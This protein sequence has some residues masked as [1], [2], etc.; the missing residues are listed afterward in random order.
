M[1]RVV[2]D[3]GRSALSI[4][5]VNLDNLS[6]LRR[7]IASI[8]GQTD[9]DFE[10][11]V[12]DG[13]SG[14]GSR[15]LLAKTAGIDW[16]VS[17]RDAGVYE[18]MNK[19]IAKASG[20]YVLFL[21]SGDALF[22]PDTVRKTRPHFGSADIVYGNLRI[23]GEQGEW[24]G[25]MPD[26]IDLR[27]MMLDT[28][29]HPVS[30]I[31]RDLFRRHGPY[32]TAFEICGDYDWFFN[33]IVDKR[34]TTRHLD[35]FIAVFDLIGMSSKPENAAKVIAERHRAQRKWLTERQIDAFWVAERRR[36]GANRPRRR[37]RELAGGS[38]RRF[39]GT[40]GR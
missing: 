8:L 19:G 3:H 21:N 14:D 31:R 13:G 12:V 25:F 26:L 2:A 10:Y 37:V 24:D 22:D 33:V 5:T 17:E 32:D 1:R 35:Q 39:R 7:T 20:E 29:W 27:Q 4:I 34:V 6:G 16:W 36:A 9:R 40:F 15:E 18:A 38:L 30:F 28:L 11:L 23:E